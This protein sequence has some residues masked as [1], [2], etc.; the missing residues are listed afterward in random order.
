MKI[1][2]DTNTG[3][4]GALEGLVVLEMDALNPAQTEVLVND[5]ADS[6]I[7]ALGLAVG[8]PVLPM[9][10]VTGFGDLQ[11]GNTVS[12]SPQ[13]LRDEAEL[14]IEI[15]DN[16]DKELFKWAYNATDE[17]LS[18]VGNYVLQTDD[19]WLNYDRLVLEGLR[20][21]YAEYESSN[22]ALAK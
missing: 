2:I 10:E 17:Q 14:L 4:W 13:A 12:Y 11:Y 16:S 18:L 6:E 20:W 22:Q 5:W 15:Y 9:L 1:W 21:A 8:K 7:N 3:T 19:A